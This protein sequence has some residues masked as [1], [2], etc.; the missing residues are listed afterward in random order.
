M[1]GTPESTSPSPGPLAGRVRILFWITA[2]YIGVCLLRSI[3]VHHAIAGVS[4]RSTVADYD[5]LS[6]RLDLYETLFSPFMIACLTAFGA[7]ALSCARSRGLF[8]ASGACALVAAA[9]MAAMWIVNLTHAHVSPGTMRLMSTVFI[10]SEPV[11]LGLAMG[12]LAMILAKRGERGVGGLLWA[13]VPFLAWPILFYLAQSLGKLRIHNPWGSFFLGTFLWSLGAAWLLYFAA[14]TRAALLGVAAARAA[15]PID[16]EHLGSG[17][18]PA[19]NGLRLY[20]DALS[21]RLGVTVFGYLILLMGALGGS[22]GM[23]QLVG[24]VLPLAAVITGIAMVVGIYRFAQQP[25]LSPARSPAWIAF[26]GMVCASV[27]DLGSLILTLRVM[28]A[29][30]HSYAAMHRAMDS[31]DTAQTLSLWAMGAGFFSLLSLLVAFGKLANFIGPTRLFGRV[32]GVAGAILM[33]ALV[34]IGFRAAIAGGH[35]VTGTGVAA[36]VLVAGFALLTVI[37]YI[38]LVRAVERSVR[39]RL[40]DAQALPPARVV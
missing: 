26:A 6:Q 10:V 21:W 40:G 14:R 16:L 30:E 33:V 25:A 35:L 8:I 32:V 11:A 27:T 29:D 36:G 28:G 1:P 3:L 9:M 12:G 18:L 13:A 38:G 17:W 22:R 7:T 24:W 37:A 20:A 4:D 5:A 2:A 39:D 23:V 15:E 34:V 19:A 31:A